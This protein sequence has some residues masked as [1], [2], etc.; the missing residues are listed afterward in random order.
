RAGM[1]VTAMARRADRLEALVSEIEAAG[2][3][4]LAAPG[5]VAKAG[6]CERAIER[7]AERFGGVYAVFACAG[8]G[9]QEAVH[10]MPDADLR[11]MFEANFFGSLNIIRPALDVMLAAQPARGHVLMCSSCLSKIAI[12]W[13]AAY[14][15]TKSCQEIFGRAMA[16]E[17][18]GR[19][20]HVSTIHPAGTRTELFEVLEQRSRD[21][22]ITNMS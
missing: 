12:P 2:G 4:A 15:A 19:G 5:D 1:P 18:R 9:I 7:C 10:E 21:E 6:D 13:Y 11:A 14:C 3:R 16:I 20:V 17:L 22:L 8:F